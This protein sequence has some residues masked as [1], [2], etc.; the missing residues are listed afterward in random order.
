MKL[1]KKTGYRVDREQQDHLT[2][3]TVATQQTEDVLL[4]SGVNP[5]WTRHRIAR[6]VIG[7]RRYEVRYSV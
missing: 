3:G 2:R 5:S 6:W 4:F 7:K 1:E